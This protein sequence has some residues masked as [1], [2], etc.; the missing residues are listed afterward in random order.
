MPPDWQADLE[1]YDSVV[2]RFKKWQQEQQKTVPPYR[3]AIQDFNQALHFA[4]N[5]YSDDYVQRGISWHQLGDYK[6]AIGDFDRY[7]AADNTLPKFTAFFWRGVSWYK[8]DNYQNALS[9]FNKAIQGYPQDASSYFWR[10]NTKYHLGDYKG[11]IA[12]S[13]TAIRLDPKS[14]EIKDAYSVRRQAQQRLDSQ[15]HLP[16][17]N[18]Q[19]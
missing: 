13:T 6:G 15:K 14:T 18:P 11:A 1:L 17:K 2:E 9:D 7:I 4:P 5:V 10:A 3:N 12:D 8:L 16:I 19:K